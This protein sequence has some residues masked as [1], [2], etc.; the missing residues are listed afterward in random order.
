MKVYVAEF[1][2]EYYEN[3]SEYII[4]V[5]DNADKAFNAIVAEA[6]ERGEPALALK[7]DIPCNCYTYSD[8]GSAYYIYEYEVK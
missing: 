3:E 6:T 7:R 8:G 5:Y 4:G 2:P 1:V